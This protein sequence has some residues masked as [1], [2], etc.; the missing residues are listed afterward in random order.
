VSQKVRR[1]L[2]ERAQKVERELG[3]PDLLLTAPKAVLAGVE[4]EVRESITPWRRL[5]S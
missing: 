3:E 4:S 1:R 2:D 5:R